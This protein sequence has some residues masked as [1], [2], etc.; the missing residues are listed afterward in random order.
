MPA[1]DT[2]CGA[3]N[4]WAVGLIVHRLSLHGLGIEFDHFTHGSP[5]IVFV[6][7]VAV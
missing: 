2:K 4:V 5:E 1:R 6:L 3:G 7:I